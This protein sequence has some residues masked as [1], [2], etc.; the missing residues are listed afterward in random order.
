MSR[1]RPCSPRRLPLAAKL[2]CA[3][4]ARSRKRPPPQLLRVP[5]TPL[6]SRDIVTSTS[7]TEPGRYLPTSAKTRHHHDCSLTL[8]SLGAPRQPLASP[9]CLHGHHSASTSSAPSVVPLT[10]TPAGCAGGATSSCPLH[11]RAAAGRCSALAKHSHPGRVV[12]C[13]ALAMLACS[14]RRLHRSGRTLGTSSTPSPTPTKTLPLHLI[15]FVI[16][17]PVVL[18]LRA[19]LSPLLGMCYSIG[20]SLVGLCV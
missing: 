13:L 15:P 5:P 8:P 3:S 4:S 1:R 16:C 12:L 10:P 7:G 14:T 19:G 17:L 20:V 18:C 9:C 6:L 2:R 11:R